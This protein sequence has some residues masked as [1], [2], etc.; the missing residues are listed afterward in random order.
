MGLQFC[1]WFSFIFKSLGGIG[2]YLA[3][4][5]PNF[6]WDSKITCS[7]RQTCKICVKP[8]C[9]VLIIMGPVVKE[10]QLWHSFL[11]ILKGS[12]VAS[13]SLASRGILGAQ[14]NNYWQKTERL[15]LRRNSRRN[16]YRS[17]LNLQLVWREVSGVR[18]GDDAA[19]SHFPVK[20]LIEVPF[21]MG[22][23]KHAFFRRPSE[24]FWITLV[25]WS[26]R[27]IGSIPFSFFVLWQNI[28][29]TKHDPH[30]FQGFLAMEVSKHPSVTAGIGHFGRKVRIVPCN[31]TL[32]TC[33]RT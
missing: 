23:K 16:T 33:R 10:R 20:V 11:L 24:D 28:D 9:S 32:S 4:F 30:N 29:A 17:W 2:S 22:V 25:L 14:S 3:I 1:S 27:I 21:F 13:G 18:S 8:T 26:R 6:A 7:V 12:R 5:R 19:I 15:S 31:K